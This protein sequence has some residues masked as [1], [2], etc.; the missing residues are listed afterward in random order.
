MGDVNSGSGTGGQAGVGTR[1]ESNRRGEA[2][3]QAL[4][5]FGIYLTLAFLFFGPASWSA[6]PRAIGL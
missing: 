1:T 2:L 3:L 5:A 6:Y 4:G